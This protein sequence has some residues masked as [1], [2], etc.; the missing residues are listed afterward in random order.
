MYQKLSVTFINH[1]NEELRIQN[2]NRLEKIKDQEISLMAYLSQSRYIFPHFQ[3]FF[4]TKRVSITGWLKSLIQA[5]KD[6]P[7]ITQVLLK[8]YYFEYKNH[9]CKCCNYLDQV[10]YYPIDFRAFQWDNVGSCG[11]RGCKPVKSKILRSKKFA[12]LAANSTIL[13]KG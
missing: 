9:T 4:E 3:Q 8:Y 5:K 6:K 13:Q 10:F 1:L 11:S 12:C 7:L 2:W